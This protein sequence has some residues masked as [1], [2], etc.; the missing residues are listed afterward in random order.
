MRPQRVD[1]VSAL[2]QW[3]RGLLRDFDSRSVA[4]LKRHCP[5]VRA[6][7]PFLADFREANIQ[8]EADKDRLIIEK[9]AEA[10]LGGSGG[11]DAEEIFEMT[12]DLDRAFVRKLSRAR[13]SVRLDYEEIR[14]LR[15]ERI[16]LLSETVGR[17]L[18]GWDG[19]GALADAARRAFT[20]KGLESSVFHILRLYSQETRALSR[21]MRLPLFF[22]LAAGALSRQLY[23]AMEAVSAELASETAAAVFGPAD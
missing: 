20:R 1:P 23:E 3:D 22:G 14:P 5:A 9:S 21:S 13:L 15:T 6:L 19:S 7:M 4:E 16:A 10:H 17:L 12:R 18:G 2:C 8:K 11:V